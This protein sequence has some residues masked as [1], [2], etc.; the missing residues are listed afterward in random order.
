MLKIYFEV[1]KTVKTY[2]NTMG[3]RASE[4]FDDVANDLIEKYAERD[5]F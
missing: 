4:I 2:S 1:L 5:E 3:K